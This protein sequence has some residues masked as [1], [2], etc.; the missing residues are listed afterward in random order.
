MITLIIVVVS[1]LLFSQIVCLIAPKKYTEATDDAYFHLKKN[2]WIFPKYSGIC[3]LRLRESI[4]IL[5]IQLGFG[6]YDRCLIIC[7]IAF[8]LGSGKP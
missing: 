5:K 8:I 7:N 2:W 6:G 4:V 3:F 1:L